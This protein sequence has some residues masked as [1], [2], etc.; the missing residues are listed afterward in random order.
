VFGN[1]EVTASAEEGHMDHKAT[2][3]PSH[4]SFSPSHLASGLPNPRS[5]SH[6]QNSREKLQI[7]WHLY[8]RHRLSTSFS[9]KPC[10]VEIITPI[11]QVKKLRQG[12]INLNE[13]T[14]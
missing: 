10:D 13:N 14:S 8:L 6:P 2:S 9:T 4:P 11:F 1:E 5:V 7:W 12:K 3:P